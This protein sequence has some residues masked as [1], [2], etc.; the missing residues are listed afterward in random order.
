MISGHGNIETAVNAI[1]IGAYDFI[2]KP[3]KSDRLL[4]IVE[5]A[6]EAARLRRE[7]QELRLRDRRRRRSD[8]RIARGGPV[9]SADREGGADRQP[10]ADHRPGRRRQ[11]SRRPPAAC[12]LAPGQRADRRA[13]LRD[14]AAGSARDRAV[15]HRSRRRASRA[16]SA[17]SSRRMAARCCST[18]SPTCRSKPRAR[19]SACCRSRPSSA[20]AA[21]IAS[22]SMS[23]S[24]PRPT[25]ISP[26]R[27]APGAS[28]R[29][30]SI[31]STSCRS[32]C[33]RCASGARI[34]RCSPGIS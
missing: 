25:A 1:K 28:A 18:R 7:N 20:S 11:G 34:F 4:L 17:P 2:E 19:S 32:R 29:I 30:C 23:A 12:A 3:F 26:R 33:R 22:R 27:S 9:A 15:R 14:D 31:A 10:R 5:R 16:R 21:A 24:S 6:I 8:R 13:Q